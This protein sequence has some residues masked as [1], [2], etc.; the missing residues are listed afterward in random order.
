M[1]DL[2]DAFVEG[3]GLDNGHSFLPSPVASFI[4]W[5][6]RADVVDRFR[7]F[8]ERYAEVF[9]EHDHSSGDGEHNH[10]AYEIYLL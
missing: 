2:A 7:I 6:E 10:Q 5:S 1:A 8:F 3:V 4:G 9:F